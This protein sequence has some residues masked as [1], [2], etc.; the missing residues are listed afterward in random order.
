MDEFFES[1]LVRAATID[2]LLSADFDVLAG[3]K[4]DTD[5][6]ARRLSAWCRNCA[7]GDWALFAKRLRA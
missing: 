3:P 1:L 4:G 2:K 6:A 5:R 7:S